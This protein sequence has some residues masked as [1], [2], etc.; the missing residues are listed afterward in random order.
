MN[1]QKIFN[2]ENY[3]NKLY[4][5]NDIPSNE[6][7][8]SIERLSK[9]QQVIE[10]KDRDNVEISGDVHDV[11]FEY[12]PVSEESKEDVENFLKYLEQREDYKEFLNVGDWREISSLT[13]NFKNNSDNSINFQKIMPEGYKICTSPISLDT[14]LVI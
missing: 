3:L 7:D 12:S 13:V 8:K 1:E 4:K 9:P 2:T 14:N 5:R 6:L 11:N 10:Y